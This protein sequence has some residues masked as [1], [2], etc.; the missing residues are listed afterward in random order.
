MHSPRK[1]ASDLVTL[2]ET[3]LHLVLELS[4]VTIYPSWI[5]HE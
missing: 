1:G 5:Q 2:T 4:P 3:A